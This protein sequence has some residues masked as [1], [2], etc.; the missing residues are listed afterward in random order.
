MDSTSS[1]FIDEP[2][3][4]KTHFQYLHDKC[5]KLF[6]L[7]NDSFR[8]RLCRF[9]YTDM[10]IYNILGSYRGKHQLKTEEYSY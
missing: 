1:V 10:Y 4:S 2:F 7:F 8:A 6:L 9:N 3:K 5:S